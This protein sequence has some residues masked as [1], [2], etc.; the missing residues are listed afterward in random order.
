[1]KMAYGKQ[2]KM[3]ECIYERVF[4]NM[5]YLH[6]CQRV[7]KLF[8]ERQISIGKLKIAPEKFKDTVDDI[9]RRKRNEEKDL[10][11]KKEQEKEV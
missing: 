7:S 3:Y 5:K 6:R 11:R 10:E 4:E 2:K 9:E 8:V 1:M